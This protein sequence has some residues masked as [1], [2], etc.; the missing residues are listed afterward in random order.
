M[1]RVNAPIRK[2]LLATLAS[3][4]LVAP[5]S[6]C[7]NSDGGTQPSPSNPSS[8]TLDPAAAQAV[9]L[10][11]QG[12]SLAQ[13]GKVAEATTTFNNVLTIDP[14]NKF[15]LYNLGLLAQQQNDSAAAISR[16]DAALKIDPKYTPAMYNK[17]ILLEATDHA[18]A[19]ALYES[20]IGINPQASTAYLRLSGLYA[21]AG[22]QAKAKEMKDKA[23]ALDPALANVNPPPPAPPAAPTTTTPSTTK[24][25]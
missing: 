20:I 6:A 17:A 24:A 4:A 11:N 25:R 5:I 18:A 3:L 12:I 19:I 8:G 15:A 7:N 16:Y 21:A 14:A 9:A 10:L 1:S 2:A 23:V 22:D 13:A